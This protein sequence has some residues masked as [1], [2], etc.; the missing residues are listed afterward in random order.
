MKAYCGWTG[1]QYSLFRVCF[2]VYLCVHFVALIPWAAETFSSVGVL[3]DAS[4]SPLL[5]AFPNILA[6][7]DGPL[8]VRLLIFTASIAAF[9][10]S[11]GL[12]DKI[13]AVFMWYVFACLFGRNPLTSNPSLPFV[14]WMLLAHV[15]LPAKPLGALDARKDDIADTMKW[16]YPKELFICAW[17]LMSVAYSYSGVMKLSSPSW[18]DGSALVEVLN[19]PL[20]RPGVL[21]DLV[22][23]FPV[24]LLKLMTWGALGLEIFF[25]P[26]AFVARVRPVLWLGMLLMHCGLVA[27]VQFADLSFG[28]IVLHLFTFNPAW[29]SARKGEQVQW[30][31]YDGECGLCHRWVKLCLAEDA[32]AVFHFSPNQ[33]EK[34]TEVLTKQ[35]RDHLPDSIVVVTDADV[36][37]TKSSAV[38]FILQQLGGVW[39]IVSWGGRAIP[40]IVR[41][42]FYDFVASVRHKIF[43]KE[44]ALC[45]LMPGDLQERFVI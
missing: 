30:L 3:P 4:T 28:M 40:R 34:I 15:I 13:A 22:L 43:P 11:I 33:G 14:G 9:C 29:L 42:F 1:G 16:Q 5:Y 23:E 24:P 10:F 41:D 45:P 26:L 37:L 2:G 27:L 39:R 18:V 6:L 17:I 12:K 20:A 38:L 44:K 35:Q 7:F 8:F 32:L 25:V 36:L 31:F 21:R 19:N